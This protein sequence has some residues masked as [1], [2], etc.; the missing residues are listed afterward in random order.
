MLKVFVIL[1]AIFATNV[2]SSEINQFNYIEVTKIKVK[3]NIQ[4]VSPELNGYDVGL[5]K[6]LNEYFF[7]NGLYQ[8]YGDSEHDTDRMIIGIGSLYIFKSYISPFGQVDY[9]NI[10]SKGY[11]TNITMK[12]KRLRLGGFGK[13]GHFGYKI[14]VNRY[15]TEEAVDEDDITNF[16]EVYYSLNNNFSL[17]AEL[18]DTELSDLY[19]IGVRYQ[20]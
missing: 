19:K 15:F 3:I 13:I 4:S 7:I 2:Y 10:T 12:Q 18:E 17:V 20:F 5:N 1:L 8:Q 14:G 9:L 6:S 16:L 11:G